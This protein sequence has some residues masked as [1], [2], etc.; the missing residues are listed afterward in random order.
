MELSETGL[1][2]Q[3]TW[4]EIPKH[5]PFVCLDAFV[6]MPN[7]IHG[8]LIIDKKDDGRYGSGIELEMDSDM[9]EK[10][11]GTGREKACLFSTPP[12]T[13]QHAINQ[14]IAQYYYWLFLNHYLRYLCHTRDQMKKL[15][16]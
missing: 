4:N 8:I 12:N 15:W 1:F 13:T 10:R 9:V 5:F 16:A 11:Q 6:A 7:H 2:A 3:Q 14:L